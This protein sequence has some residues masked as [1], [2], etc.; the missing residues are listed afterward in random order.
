MQR[1]LHGLII[2]SC[3]LFLWPCLSSASAGKAIEDAEVL[4]IEAEPKG[5]FQ[6]QGL[7]VSYHR[8][9]TGNTK[10]KV[11]GASELFLAKLRPVIEDNGFQHRTLKVSTSSPDSQDDSLPPVIGK[12]SIESDVIIFEPWFPLSRGIE[13]WIGVSKAVIDPDLFSVMHA[14]ELIY[15]SV[16]IPKED[17]IPVAY[18]E[19]VFPSKNELPEN[20]LKF[21]LHFSHPMSAGNVYDY[22]HLLDEKGDPLHLPFLELGEELWNHDTQRLTLLFDPGRI[23]TGLVPNLEQGMV[24][25]QGK[26]Y[27]LKIDEAWLD[28]EGRPL[29]I[30]F[31]KTFTV[32]AADRVSPNPHDWKKKCPKANTRDPLA[33][34]F[35]ESLDEALLQRLLNVLDEKGDVIEGSV[36]V[37]DQETRWEFIPEGMWKAGDHRLEIETILEDLAGNSIARTFELDK[38]RSERYREGPKVV[39]VDFVVH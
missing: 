8:T 18:V 33:I 34:E 13:F 39:F 2:G 22:I 21:Y 15:F 27:T 10:V 28:A 12:V 6:P 4:T 9:G 16:L 17:L 30:G 20:L 7:R 31:Q 1:R 23:K 5:Q 11:H 35:H 3:T 14:G 24:L 29:V 19:S 25:E 26:D 38:T 32:V 37:S 36:V